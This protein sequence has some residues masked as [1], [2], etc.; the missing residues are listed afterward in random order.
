MKNLKRVWKESLYNFSYD[1]DDVETGNSMLVYNA[2]TNALAVMDKEHRDMY[3]QYRDNGIGIPD[4]E[5]AE[6]LKTGG[7]LLEDSV[8]EI[9]ILKE[10]LFSDRYRTDYL[11]LT[12]AAT[13]DCN[14]R[15]IY[16]YEKNSLKNSKM[17]PEKQD[18]L[19]KYIESRMSSISNLSIVWYGGEPL[20]AMDVI[21]SLSEKIIRLC[22]DNSVNYSASIVTNGYLL[23]PETAKKLDK[24]KVKHMQITIDG[25]E[26]IHNKRRPLAG[27]QGTFK[28]ILKN[29]KDC[30]GYIDSISIRINV[31][32]ENANEINTLIAQI[33]ELKNGGGNVGF[34]LGFVEAHNDCYLEN[35]CMTAEAFSVKHY[36]FMKD[37]NVDFMNAYPRIVSN[38]CGAD[39]YLSYVIDYE[40]NIYKCWNDIGITDRIVGNTGSDDEKSGT[41]NTGLYYG[42]MH[43]AA[44]EDEGCKHCNLLP[45]CMGGC[46]YKRLMGKERCVDKKYILENY[47][48]DCAKSLLAKQHNLPDGRWERK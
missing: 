13:S 26:E 42:Y 18:E 44:T 48:K 23:N 31:D 2:R 19:M 45:I 1:L 10:N 24:Y 27:G 14:F 12:I 37:N 40:G 3:I 15:C 21:E 6:Q 46:P 34:Y 9:S 20:L 5:F 17:S 4:K 7:Y 47:L 22:G 33:S 16:C 32:I 35:K 8:D 39:R 38:Y 11:S 41:Y 29:V 28:T 36:E 43:Y 25:P 30:K